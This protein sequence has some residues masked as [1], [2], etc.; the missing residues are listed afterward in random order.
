[1]KVKSSLLVIVV[2]TMMLSAISPFQKT[3]KV[4]AAEV[5]QIGIAEEQVVVRVYY[6]E[7]ADINKLSGFDLFEFNNLD[8]KYVLV[9]I[10]KSNLYQIEALGFKVEID[11]FE[12]EQFNL[13]A[14]FFGSEISTIPGYECYRTVEETYADAQQLANTY[15]T[16]TSWIDVGDSWEKSVGQADGYDMMVMKITN[17]AIQIDKPKLFII[18]SI[19]A[20]EYTPA[21]LAL[22]YAEYLLNNYGTDADV[23]WVIDYH[24]IH[25]MFQANPDG[26]KEAEAGLSWRKNTNENYCGA[27]STNRGAD[28]NRNF[29]YEWGGV[30]ASTNPCD[31]TYRGPAPD[32]E[33]E[34]RAIRDYMLSLFPDQRDGGAA[35]DDTTG[36]FLDLHTYGQYVLW[37]WG[38]SDNTTPNDAQLQ[39]LGRKFAYFNGYRPGQTG[40]DLYNC[41]GV[42]NDFAY[43][44]LGIAAYTFEMGTAFFQSCTTFEN[45][46][47]PTNLNA[48]LYAGKVV[49][50]PYKTP[51]G[52]DALSLSLSDDVVYAGETPTLTATVNDT[53]FNQNYGTEPVQSISQAEY[54]ID[55]PPWLDGAVAIPM[56]ATDGSFNNNVENVTATIGTSG[57]SQ[58]R[59]TL[60]V[61]GLDQGGNWGAFSAIFLTVEYS[62]NNAP[63]ADD[64]TVT[65]DE[66]SSWGITLTGS[67]PDDDPIT[68][69]VVAEPQYGELTGT[70]PELIYTPD[71]NFNGTDSFT[72]VANDGMVNSPV[73]TVSI[74]I[75]PVGDAPVADPQS[76]ST[77][78]NQGVAITLT[79]SDVDGDE[80]NYLLVDLP[81]NGTIDGLEPN[82]VYTPDSGFVG[83][84]TFT[85]KANDGLMDSNYATVTVTVNP[86]G[87]VQIFFDD[88]ESDMGWTRNPNGSDTATTGLWERANPESV[89]YNYYGYTQLGTTVS[90]NND[91]VTG[92]LAGS[93]AGSYDIDNGV[94]SIRSPQ[95]T[96][97]ANSQLSLSFWYYLAHLNNSSSADYL[98]VSVIGDTTVQIFEELG[99]SNTDEA[100]WDDFSVDISQFAGQTIQIHIAAADASSGSLV[101]A[102]IDDV[103]I[104]GNVTN[105]SPVADEQSVETAEDTAVAITLTGS[106]LD[107]DP[108]SFTVINP[109]IHGTLTGTA[110]DLLY[111]PWSNY[112]GDDTF[113]FVVN[114][115][116]S[117]SLE[118]VVDINVTPVNDAPVAGENL[119]LVL[120]EDGTISF[121]LPVS[122]VDNDVLT[123][124]VKENLSHGAL[125]GEMPNLTYTP[126]PEF[127]GDDRFTYTVSDGLAE[128]N[129]AQVFFTINSV[130][131]KPIAYDDRLVLPEDYQIKF[132]LEGFDGDSDPL[133]Y[134]ILTQPLHGELV[135]EGASYRFVTEPNYYGPDSFTFKVNDGQE[136]SD[137]ATVTITITS[138]NDEPVAIPQTLSTPIN[139]PLSITL[140]GEDVDGDLLAY[141]VTVEPLNG[142]LTGEAP[143]LTYT[144]GTDFTGFDVFTFRV[145]DPQYWNSEAQVSITVF[146]GGNTAPIATPRNLSIQE[147]EAR[148]ITLTGTD[149]DGDPL[150][151]SISSEPQFGTLTGVL[152]NLVYTPNQNHFGT[153][154]FTF[155]A[156]DGIDISAPATV[157]IEIESVNDAPIADSQS[158]VT[159]VNT[160]IDVVLTGS[161]IEGSPVYMLI[162]DEPS[163]GS[164]SGLEPNLTY[165]PDQGWTGTDSFTFKVNDG[166]MDSAPATIQIVVEPVVPFEV[167]FDDFETDKGWV[168]NPFS[169]DT[170]ING[171]LERG[172]P[173]STFFF[174]YKQL[175]YTV[176]GTN[177]LVTGPLAGSGVGSY[178]VDSGSTSV[179][180]PLIALPDG[181]NLIL[182]FSYY[183]AHAS[184][185]SYADYLRVKVVGSQST[186]ILQELGA[187]NDDDARWQSFTYD[188]SGFAGQTI[189]I[190]IQVADTSTESL[191]EA[192]ID[193]VLITAE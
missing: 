80:L 111:T 131:D 133:S 13:T 192:A 10:D 130:N 97:P 180:S 69:A 107:G 158:L 171:V 82:I 31:A 83:V 39:T 104:E 32:S 173:E 25:I 58:G 64:L 16:L 66:D 110:P 119:N 7:I 71:A 54:Y 187:N 78:F 172:N 35:P 30:G 175:G 19:H 144:P 91:L 186:Q 23:T 128:S 89:Y 24:E 34:T 68:F 123:L 108:L 127:F 98:R 189:Y 168:F 142:T 146:E 55:T 137:P 67:D 79:G 125:S 193:D 18:A 184:N 116:M 63:V 43:G 92:R 57:L 136:D 154:S 143:N 165:T 166:L 96:L 56:A 139:I 95:I 150:T 115:G 124:V 170:A 99:A 120:D 121:T 129:E 11:E 87:P 126:D 15:P 190:H 42:T 9:A 33:P 84:D 122:D 17:Q 177:A 100:D 157:S 61:R 8:E 12:T 155:T 88:F 153:D 105:T 145:N 163:H 181:H 109:P 74:T 14:Q 117:N 4:E 156:S 76:V 47:A 183:F 90:G 73:A 102:A 151:F 161:D 53:R 22:R 46:I 132:S 44:E 3:E 38:Y 29:S 182:S 51:L 191:V 52:P 149:A 36:I 152:P 77:M 159:Q 135:G 40:Q 26:R 176:S 103:L 178:D 160:P 141:A 114:D 62:D 147:D 6:Q 134:I 164:L 50:T 21:E 5:C 94:T 113:T 65:L 185:S 45:T 81:A 112:F 48:L 106:D 2:L 86:P 174:G 118:A 162:V 59:H 167:F 60:Y 27:T 49:R 70:T 188:L 169:T 148:P 75:D 138:E 101:E 140:M 1:M 28:L 37:P 85:F 72:Y 41:S 93:S 20:R 179:R